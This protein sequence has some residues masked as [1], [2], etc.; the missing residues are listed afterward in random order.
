MGR[1][2]TETANEEQRT[3]TDVSPGCWSLAGELHFAPSIALS[4]AAAKAG[5]GTSAGLTFTPR[6]HHYLVV[7]NANPNQG[8]VIGK[9]DCD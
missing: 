2:C 9:V 6:R 3:S 1:G 5:R 8:S 7:V 4:Q